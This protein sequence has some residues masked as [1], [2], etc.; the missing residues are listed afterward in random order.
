MSKDKNNES[1]RMFYA[2]KLQEAK[3]QIDDPNALKSWSIYELNE[4]AELLKANFEKFEA[5]CMAKSC[6]QEMNDDALQNF[7]TECTKFDALYVRLKA[8][9]QGRIEFLKANPEHF[10]EE[11]QADEKMQQQQ[12]KTARL[13][14]SY[15][16]QFNGSMN[17]WFVFHD[18]IE[19]QLYKNDSLSDE[20]KMIELVQVVSPNVLEALGTNGFDKTWKKMIGMYDSKYKLGQFYARKLTN[21]GKVQ[22]ASAGN[23]Q[24]ILNEIETIN[25]AFDRIGNISLEAMMVFAVTSKLDRETMRA[26]ERY[27]NILAISWAQAENEAQK[28]HMPSLEALRQFLQ[29]ECQIYTNEMMDEQAFTSK[30]NVTESSNKQAVNRTSVRIEAGT[31]GCSKTIDQS[32]SKARSSCP[33]H[34]NEYHALFKCVKYLAMDIEKRVMIISEQGLCI[35]CLRKDHADPCTDPRS[36]EPCPRCRPEIVYHNSTVCHKNAFCVRP[37]PKQVIVNTGNANDDD[38]DD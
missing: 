38:W 35:K 5:K 13:K 19:E 12:A 17:E 18:A 23:M 24:M 16:G 20:E 1:K 37:M 26:W 15:Q 32:T 11:T 22:I 10:V 33:L 8:K 29:D 21:L 27:R 31:S 14:L 4:R 9:L 3:K 2:E 36:N 30:C 25:N 7:T 34:I 6:E 28:N